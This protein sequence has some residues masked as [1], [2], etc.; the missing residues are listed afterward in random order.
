MSGSTGG[1]YGC[2]GETVWLAFTMGWCAGMSA[3]R[4]LC[5]YS[6][7]MACIHASLI[8][9]EL[10]LM[11]GRGGEGR[12]GE[13]EGEEGEGSGREDGMNCLS[14]SVEAV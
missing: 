9:G 12:R 4:I 5:F 6:L 14:V 10:L 8:G 13:G 3:V 11:E 2:A 1:R 7:L